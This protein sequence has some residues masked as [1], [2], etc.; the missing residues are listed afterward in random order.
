[1]KLLELQS[2]LGRLVRQPGPNNF[3]ATSAPSELACLADTPGFRFTVEVQR[4]WC[5]ARCTKAAWLTLSILPTAQREALISS[6]VNGGGG[7]A[8]FV[9]SESDTFLNFIAK[10]L[11]DPSHELTI[12]RM[13][14]ATLRAS[15]G[16]RN[17]VPR[18]VSELEKL[19]CE[20]TASPYAGVVQ[21]H[22]EPRFVLSVFDSGT[23]PPLSKEAISVLF[24]PGLELLSRIATK[25]EIRLLSHLSRP[26]RFGLLFESGYRRE[27][28]EDLFAV[29]ATDLSSRD[30]QLGGSR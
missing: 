28:I 26:T 13:E 29:G 11:S 17:F 21:F 30:C 15:E 14:Q 3:M 4:S 9:A 1:M 23:F 2:E 24:A 6:W 7:T 22:A 16:A 8:S 5:A 10:H 12:C 19:D 25:E 27:T 20:L 18:V